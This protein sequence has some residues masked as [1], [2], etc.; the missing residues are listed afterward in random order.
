MDFSNYKFRAH[1]VGKIMGGA[2]KPL[3]EEQH[4]T[5]SSLLAKHRSNNKNLSTAQMKRY[6]FLIKKHKDVEKDLTENQKTEL[7]DLILKYEST[8]KNLT[9]NQ[10]ETLGDLHRKK[11]SKLKLDQSAKKF[12]EKLVWE[13]LTGRTRNITEKYLDKGIRCEE[14]GITLLSNF[15]DRLFLKNEERREN[16]FF[17]GECDN[18]QNECIDDIKNSWEYH[19]FPL[20]EDSIRNSGYEWQL[21]TY[22]DL[23]RFKKSRLIYT[24]VDTPYKLVNDEIRALDWQ[25]DILDGNGDVIESG[26]PLVVETVINHIYTQKGLEEFCQQ[27]G[28]IHLKWFKGIFKEIPKEIRIK[29]FEHPYCDTRNQQLKEMVLLAREYM[30]ELVSLLGDSIV[31]INNL[32]SA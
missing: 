16:D 8:G 13:E 12:L 22:M 15:E 25:H 19:T 24:L 23:W 11:K 32:K 6:A 26:I 7:F 2:P 28:N 5:Y 31:A 17:N 3:T 14:K 4:K 29:I 20:L 10:I 21:D 30:N 27:S 9:L 1:S 18:S